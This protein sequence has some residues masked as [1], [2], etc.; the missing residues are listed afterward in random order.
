MPRVS[1]TKDGDKATPQNAQLVEKDKIKHSNGT[2]CLILMFKIEI[3]KESEMVK[4]L[5]FII[6][7]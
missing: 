1:Y 3:Y 2:R 5:H 6:I 7:E 4:S